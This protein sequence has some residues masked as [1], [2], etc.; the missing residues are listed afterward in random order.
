[1]KQVK[2]YDIDNDTYHGGIMLDNGDV[3]CGCCGGL[4]PK[5]EKDETWSLVTEYKY[6]VDLTEEICGDDTITC[7]TNK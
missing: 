2:I 3:I 1:M 7:F 5:D 4:L 6:W